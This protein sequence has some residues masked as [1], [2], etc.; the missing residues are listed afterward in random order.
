MKRKASHE[1]PAR[2]RVV[3]AS[4]AAKNFGALVDRVRDEQAAYVVERSGVPV[5][6]IIP[7]VRRRA[8]VA[9]LVEAL[10]GGPA[11]G[12]RFLQDVERGIA[13]FN[14]PS[15]PRDPWAS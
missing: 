9:D 2:N 14:T 6:E 5:V 3:S 12:E 1:R 4:E 10:H 15:V 8:T 7:V 13:H 11:V